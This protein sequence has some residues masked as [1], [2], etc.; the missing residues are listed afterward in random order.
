MTAVGLAVPAVEAWYLCRLDAQVTEANRARGLRAGSL[1]Y[2][3]MT[4]KRAVYGQDRPSMA[5]QRACA[6]EAAT[7]LAADIHRLEQDF[8]NGFGP[9]ARSVRLWGAG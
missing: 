3:T 2:T 9:F 5:T 7:R 4:L 8:P 1:P 6:V